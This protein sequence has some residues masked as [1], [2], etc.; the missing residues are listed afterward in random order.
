MKNNQF[1]PTTLRTVGVLFSPVVPCKNIVSDGWAGR[2]ALGGRAT[3][4]NLSG[5]YLSNHKV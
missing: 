3:G 2:Q 5:L 4:K 1:Y